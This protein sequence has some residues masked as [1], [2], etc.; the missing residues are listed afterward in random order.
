MKEKKTKVAKNTKIKFEIFPGKGRKKGEFYWRACS[1][2][3][4][5]ITAIGGQGYNHVS[6]CSRGLKGHLRSLG[7]N[8]DHFDI[9]RVEK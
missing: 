2:R 8:P 7:L 5:Q 3:N 9:E 1:K 6:N 4:G